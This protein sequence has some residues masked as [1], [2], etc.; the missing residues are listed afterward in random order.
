MAM[1]EP[2]ADSI[3]PEASPETAAPIF[4][5]RGAAIVLL[6]TREG[7]RFILA[8][9]WLR[10][11]RLT[12]VRRWSFADQLRFSVQ[13]RRLVAEAG[14]DAAQAA[15]EAKRAFAWTMSAT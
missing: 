4:L 12:D 15:A 7:E 2:R 14:L 1:N 10:E 5:W 13:V 6:G 9:G 11:D 3:T 8:R